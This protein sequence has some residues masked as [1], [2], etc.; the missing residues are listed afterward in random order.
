MARSV[1]REGTPLRA[2]RD[3]ACNPMVPEYSDRIRF[4]IT[5]GYQGILLHNLQGFVGGRL[6]VYGG[7]FI[8]SWSLLAF[9]Y[10][11]YISGMV[12]QI[13]VAYFAWHL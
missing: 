13:L 12:I 2:R 11:N 1:L 4:V 8:T 5:Y 6:P 3:T 9:F 10:H 7:L